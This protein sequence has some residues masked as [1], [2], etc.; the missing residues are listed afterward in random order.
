MA[1]QQTVVTQLVNGYSELRRTSE[2]ES[3]LLAVRTV[4]EGALQRLEG[5]LR[6]DMARDSRRLNEV[7]GALQELEV[8]QRAHQESV[9][10]GRDELR[11]ELHDALR[12]ERRQLSE[13]FAATA[14]AVNDGV[15]KLR[16]FVTELSAATTREVQDAKTY[17]SSLLSELKE[18]I[19]ELQASIA[20]E[21]QGDRQVIAQWLYAM[22]DSVGK[23]VAE[24]VTE[25]IGESEERVFQRLETAVRQVQHSLK[26]AEEVSA[27]HR[28]EADRVAGERLREWHASMAELSDALGATHALAA[29][30]R[31]E[32]ELLDG[33]M[34]TLQESLVELRASAARQH[35]EIREDLARQRRSSSELIKRQLRPITESLPELVTA[36][37][38]ASEE[39][40]LK[41]VEKA[42]AKL[43]RSL[44]QAEAPPARAHEQAPGA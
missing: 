23:V 13:E 26:D 35:V 2:N 28:M 37:A 6:E 25:A 42:V 30:Q 36:A 20:A 19:A 18:S 27:R 9:A 14:G 22:A 10:T 17:T 31:E 4:V 5:G 40:T 41:R 1:H 43:R 7:A 15:G 44:Q 8:R 21:R 33:A 11:S 24:A 39:E 38:R 3:L 29:A 34:S 32:T 12:E 16:E